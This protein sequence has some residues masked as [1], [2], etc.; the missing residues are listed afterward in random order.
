MTARVAL[1]TGAARGIGAAIADV[2]AADGWTVAIGDLDQTAA[3]AP[4]PSS[5]RSTGHG[6]GLCHGY[7]RLRLGARR[8]GPHR[9]RAR[10]D[11]GA[12][13]QRRDRRHQAVRRLDRGRMGPDHRR[14]PEGHDRR[15]AAPCSTA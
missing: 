12:G 5:R 3:A 13:E 1:V 7:R 8:R 4:P 6:L 2:L 11:R 9:I 10:A 15:A 14:E